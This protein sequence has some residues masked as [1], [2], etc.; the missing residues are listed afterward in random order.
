M[1]SECNVAIATTSGKTKFNNLPKT[2]LVINKKL[3]FMDELTDC[4][5]GSENFS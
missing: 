2:A 5:S 4:L 3:N 1:T